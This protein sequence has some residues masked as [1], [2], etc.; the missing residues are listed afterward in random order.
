MLTTQNIL[1]SYKLKYLF[2]FCDGRPNIFTGIVVTVKVRKIK[3]VR[4][5]TYHDRVNTR[6]LMITTTR[7]KVFE[8]KVRV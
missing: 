4:S 5:L 2:L 6:R 8:Q 3:S 7:V 1:L